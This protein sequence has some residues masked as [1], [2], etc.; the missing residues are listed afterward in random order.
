VGEKMIRTITEKARAMMIDSQVPVQ[1]RA[2]AVN[3]ADYLHQRSPTECL[4][5]QDCRDS[6][7]SPYKTP[8]EMLHTFGKPA[9]EKAGNK[10]S[11]K[12]SIH[13]LRQFGYYVNKLIP[14]AQR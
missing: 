8:Y 10:I 12:A 1:F 3:T 9:H 6:C 11:Y 2:E 4:T 14:D 5:K 13:H 7:N